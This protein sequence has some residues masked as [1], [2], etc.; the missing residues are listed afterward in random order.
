MPS[1]GRFRILVFAGDISLPGPRARANG[2]GSFLRESLLPKYPTICL[3]PG[4]DPHSGTMRFRTAHP[5]SILDV[6]LIHCGPRENVDLLADVDEVYRR[7]D[8]RLGW[9]YDRVMVDGDSYHEGFADAYEGVY[10]IKKAWFTDGNSDENGACGKETGAA[11]GIVVVV[12]PDGY[13]GMVCRLDLDGDGYG[14]KAV[15][16][17]FDGVLRSI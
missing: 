16:K 8:E 13:V 10:G 14:E 4:A 15:A 17:W 5:P 3:S 11:G 6:F 9:D 7:F 12:R 2:F 1:D